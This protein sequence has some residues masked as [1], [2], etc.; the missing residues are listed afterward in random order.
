MK[1]YR[2]LYRRIIHNWTSERTTDNIIVREPV[3][4]T[5]KALSAKPFA[6]A[7]H[8][9]PWRCCLCVFDSALYNIII[10]GITFIL[11]TSQ[12]P[13]K[14]IAPVSGAAAG[15]ATDHSRLRLP[16]TAIELTD[17]PSPLMSISLCLYIYR[18]HR[19]TCLGHI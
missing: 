1:P 19:Q 6:V 16:T 9:S 18:P 10:H 13:L 12:S 5:I 8:A 11:R 17:A 7:L 14:V 4:K 15:T 3:Q 2:I